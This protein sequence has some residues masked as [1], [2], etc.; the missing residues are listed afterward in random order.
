MDQIRYAGLSDIPEICRI[1]TEA[2]ENMEHKEW[3]ITD[4]REYLESL[5]EE[6]GYILV[7]LSDGMI[8]GFLSVLKPDAEDDKYA[9]FVE[10]AS[11]R[12][13]MH[14]ESCA[15]EAAYR[16]RGIQQKL[17]RRAEEIERAAGTRFLLCTIHPDNA[18]SLKSALKAGYQVA[19]TSDSIYGD[20]EYLRHVCV[21]KL[22]ED[23]ERNTPQQES[24]RDTDAGYV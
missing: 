18:S 12:N 3:Y 23:A 5:V 9:R 20:G 1:M 19:A 2:Y 15:V 16:G 8:V 6:R 21:R 17:F 4:S 22:F 11:P 10:G 14:T 24:M 7:Y 13:S